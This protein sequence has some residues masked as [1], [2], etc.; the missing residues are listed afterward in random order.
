MTPLGPRFAQPTTYSPWARALL[1]GDAPAGV[2]DDGT[3]LVE[4]DARS[5]VPR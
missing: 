3:R 1:V 5:G 2:R 4:R